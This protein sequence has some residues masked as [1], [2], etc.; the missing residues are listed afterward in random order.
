VV[1]SCLRK[2]SASLKL[3]LQRKPLAFKRFECSTGR[4][5]IVMHLH[6]RA[7]R[8]L[9]FSEGRWLQ[10]RIT[11]EGAEPY[12]GR[13]RLASGTIVKA[14]QAG[15]C[16]YYTSYAYFC[17]WESNASGLWAGFFYMI[18]DGS[19][20][21]QYLLQYYAGTGWVYS[22][23]FRWYSCRRRVKTGPPAPVEIW[24]T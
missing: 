11:L 20:Y 9:R 1:V 3:T 24:T 6:K 19:F 14:A 2:G 17:G 21:V 16:S 8:R 4:N 22:G 15:A 10:A 18:P 5:E 12:V 23:C 13:L 7:V